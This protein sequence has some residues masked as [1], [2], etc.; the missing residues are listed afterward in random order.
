MSILLIIVASLLCFLTVLWL[1]RIA[2]SYIKL[3]DDRKH[4]LTQKGNK[5]PPH[6]Y[7][8]L[9]V[10]NEDKRL[11]EFVDYFI[12]TLT[13][14]YPKLRLVIITT[15]KESV[16]YPNSKTQ[17]I[18]KRMSQLHTSIQHTHTQRLS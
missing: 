8:L 18:A 2:Y 10:L 6:I 13:P 12:G 5:T 7:I 9:P 4:P 15:E 14:T 17:I 1:F 16:E 11:R 3:K